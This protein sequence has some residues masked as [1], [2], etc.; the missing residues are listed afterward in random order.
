MNMPVATPKGVVRRWVA[1]FNAA[2]AD[3]LAALYHDDA[4]DHQVALEAVH[5]RDAV[6]AFFADEFVSA[7][8]EC[9][10]VNLFEDGEWAILEWKDPNGMLGSTFFQVI[11]GRI[12]LA[13]GYWDRL[14]AAQAQAGPQSSND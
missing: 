14:S 12:K 6:R 13:R 5:G 3:A 8:M 10:P 9:V 11:D 4:T 2:D 7:T 1:A